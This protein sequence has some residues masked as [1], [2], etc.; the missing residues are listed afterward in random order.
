MR[1]MSRHCMA[2][3]KKEKILSDAWEERLKKISPSMPHLRKKEMFNGFV[4]VI[5][6]MMGKF[7]RRS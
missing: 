2:L 5:G 6:E 1:E 3:R 7:R 4:I